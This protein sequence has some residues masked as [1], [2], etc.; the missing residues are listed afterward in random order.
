VSGE[1][2]ATNNLTL[3]RKRYASRI[4]AVNIRSRRFGYAM[5]EMPAQFLD[6]GVSKFGSLRKAESRIAKLLRMFRPS[7]IVLRKVTA[8][9][10]RNSRRAKIIIRIIRR[11]AKRWSIPISFVSERTLKT[12]FRKHGKNNKYDVAALVA[13]RFPEFAWKVPSRRKFYEP[14]PWAMTSFDAAALAAAYIELQNSNSARQSEN[15][16]TGSG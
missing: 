11:Q 2:Q 16:A 8:R 5:F 15:D 12:L 14:E 3:M 13:A 9:S 10:K 4:L 6:C 1:P 7:A